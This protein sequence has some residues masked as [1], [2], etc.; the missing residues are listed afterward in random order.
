MR[1]F[2]EILEALGAALIVIGLALYTV[3]AALIAAGIFLL[4]AASAPR[5]QRVRSEL[6][7]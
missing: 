5:P 3:P 1:L 7:R 6:R 4:V 2:W